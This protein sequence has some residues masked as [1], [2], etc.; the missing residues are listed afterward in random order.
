MLSERLAT[1]AVGR[2]LTQGFA[3][4]RAELLKLAEEARALEARA[5]SRRSSASPAG[6]RSEGPPEGR[7]PSRHGLTPRQAECLAVIE[8]LT[9]AAGVPP[10]YAE[11]AAE[12]G[13]RNR[14]NAFQLVQKLIER[15][16]L[17]ALGRRGRSLVVIP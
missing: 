14:S 10:S 4:T 9:D 5:A 16:H 17:S 1:L 15:G 7:A 8:R 12:L 13:L 3:D 2:L 11:L 6:R